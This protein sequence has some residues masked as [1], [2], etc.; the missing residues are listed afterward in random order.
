MLLSP[1]DIHT[2]YLWYAHLRVTPF[3]KPAN[4]SLA[5][6]RVNSFHGLPDPALD[7]PWLTFSTLLFSYHSLSTRAL[8]QLLIFKPLCLFSPLPEILS[9][10]PLWVS[11]SLHSSFRLNVPSSGSLPWSLHEIL[12]QDRLILCWFHFRFLHLFV[13]YLWLLFSHG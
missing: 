8:L 13:N 2:P 4:S 1:N 9:S 7:G 5:L 12:L 10:L 11:P 6:R 3:L